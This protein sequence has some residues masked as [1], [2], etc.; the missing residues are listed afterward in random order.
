ML[1]KMFSSFRY[2]SW[3]AVISSLLGSAIMFA[4]GVLKTFN[5]IKSFFIEDV[6][7]TL[8]SADM[9]TVYI[10]K[11]IDAFLIAFVLFIFSYGV[12]KLFIGGTKINNEP[13]FDWINISSISD[14]KAILTE[15]I[16]VIIFV[17]FLELILLNLETLTWEVLILPI[18]IVLLALG[19]KLLGLRNI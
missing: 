12:M 9:A 6:S 17:K 16:I 14:L 1:I 2:L 19:L 11:S 18:S 15:V 3:I 8:S 7:Q 13:I 4:I 10:V 5:A